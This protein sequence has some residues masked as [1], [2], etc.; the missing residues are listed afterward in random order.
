MS[1]KKRKQETDFVKNRISKVPLNFVYHY[2]G[3]HISMRF[4]VVVFFVFC[5]LFLIFLFEFCADGGFVCACK[6]ISTG[7]NKNRANRKKIV[8]YLKSSKNLNANEIKREKNES[9]TYI[10][11]KI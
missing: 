8:F 3:V 5:F 2:Y 6:R 7:H 11:S 9:D 10:H 1:W 4:V